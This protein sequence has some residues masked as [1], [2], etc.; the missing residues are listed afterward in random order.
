[1]PHRNRDNIGK[2]LPNTPTTSLSHPSLFFGGSDLEEP[3]GESPEIYEDSITEEEQENIPFETMADNINGRNDDERIEGT[4]LI[5]ETNGDMKTKNIS[6]SALPH[7]HGLTTEDP[8]TFLF[9]FAIL[10]RTYDYAEEEKQLK[11]FPC[12]LKDA[13]LRWFME[14]PRN[15]IT[16]WAQIHQAFNNK[17]RD[18][19]RSNE[20]K[21]E[22]FRMTM[23]NDE[24]LEDYEERF[25][26]SYKQ[27]GVH[28]TLNL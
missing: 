8:N 26:L 24:S 15:S 12:T 2:F 25:Q 22:I 18:Y 19:C 7:F 1:M 13:T 5:R 6:P 9:E 21:G 17:Y 27:V 10:C 23:G 14:L 28:L 20:T 16:T 11:L 4:F 3:I